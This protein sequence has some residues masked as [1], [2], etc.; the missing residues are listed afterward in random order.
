MKSALGGPQSDSE[1]IHPVTGGII[2]AEIQLNRT[3]SPDFAGM[4]CQRFF[5]DVGCD[6]QIL[7]D[8]GSFVPVCSACAL[9]QGRQ[10]CPVSWQSAS[11]HKG[12]RTCNSHGCAQLCACFEEEFL[13][14]NYSIKEA[15]PSVPTSQ[16][17]EVLKVIEATQTF[18]CDCV[19]P[20]LYRSDI[21]ADL[22]ILRVLHLS[23][24]LSGTDT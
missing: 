18:C 23:L 1:Q 16:Q 12:G 17:V 5:M 8:T 13:S 14:L 9:F 6:F 3:L 15:L 19:G 11:R 4:V 24:T 7:G 20:A 22:G 2:P 10:E 21:Y